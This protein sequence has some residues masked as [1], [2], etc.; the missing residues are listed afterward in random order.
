MNSENRALQHV[1]KK[2]DKIS[3]FLIDPKKYIKGL[4]IFKGTLKA[5]K[6]VPEM[7]EPTGV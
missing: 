7:R 3:F 4:T 2:I 5:T 6:L 1:Q